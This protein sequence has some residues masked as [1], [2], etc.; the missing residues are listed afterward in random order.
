MKVFSAVKQAAFVLAFL[1]IFSSLSAVDSY[2][3]VATKGGGGQ[4]HQ[5]E[6]HGSSQH[7]GEHH[8]EEAHHHADYPGHHGGEG[9]VNVNAEGQPTVEPTPVYVLPSTGADN[10]D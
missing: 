10:S 4:H 2:D 7:S 6:H 9:N 5:G 1:P 8:G 3:V